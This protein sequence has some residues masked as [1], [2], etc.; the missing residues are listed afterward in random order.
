MT[1]T[2][3]DIMQWLYDT[4][5]GQAIR[6]STWMFP[7]LE[8]VHFIGLSLLMGSMLIVDLRLLGIMRDY[9]IRHA[10]AFLPWAIFGFVLNTFSGIGFVAADPFMYW[11]NPAFRLKMYMILLAGLNAAVFTIL[12]HRKVAGFGVGEETN[13]FTKVSAGLS[14]GL[15]IFIIILGRSLPT[16]EGSM[17]FF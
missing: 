15:W 8:T 12:E 14:L 1:Q 17:T 5:L 3:N 13:T 11:P 16:F 2:E 10:L 6:D 7:S 9:P 4:V